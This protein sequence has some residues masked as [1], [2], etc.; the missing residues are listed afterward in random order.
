M[1]LNYFLFIFL[2]II[3]VGFVNVYFFYSESFNIKSENINN[4][5]D[6]DK[7]YILNT[8]GEIKKE[9]IEQKEIIQEFAIIPHFMIESNVVYDFYS[10]IKNEYKLEGIKDLN[11]VIIS[12]NHFGVGENN[13]L[14]FDSKDKENKVCYSDFCNNL[15]S[16]VENKLIFDGNGKESI[17]KSDYLFSYKNGEYITKEH[18]I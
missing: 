12:P 1:K 3:S 4:N 5:L 17:F 2:F 7:K 18:G 10:K 9:N 15:Y 13:F 6:F 8:N 16:L 11:I 14:S